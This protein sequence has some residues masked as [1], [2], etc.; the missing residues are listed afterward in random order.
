MSIKEILDSAW[1]RRLGRLAMICIIPIVTAGGSAIGW[2]VWQNYTTSSRAEEV[3]A[4]AA[5]IAA[6]VK[7]LQDQRADLIDERAK[8]DLAWREKFD[9]SLVRVNQQLSTEMGTV[10]TEI[11]ELKGDI[12]EL[13]GL[14]VRSQSAAVPFSPG[15]PVASM[16]GEVN[17][18]N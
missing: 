5:A 6:D 9:A 15:R 13:K 2:I 3:A 14:I 10:R 16:L 17:V 11:G 18:P 8:A 4:K 1:V 12:G 7:V